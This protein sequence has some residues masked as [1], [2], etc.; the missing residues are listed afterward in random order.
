MQYHHVGES[1]TLVR[2]L[3]EKTK[4]SGVLATPRISRNN[5]LYYPEEL[6]KQNG[7]IVPVDLE[8]NH[9]HTIGFAKLMWNQELQRLEYVG[10]ISDH[11]VENTLQDGVEYHTSLEGGCASEPVCSAS[12]CHTACVA[13]TSIDRMALVL[14]PGIPE[15]TVNVV[16]SADSSHSL[17]S[18]NKQLLAQ[19]V[20]AKKT[21]EELTKECGCKKEA[22]GE[23]C[24]EGQVYDSEAQKCVPKSEDK[25]KDDDKKE[26]LESKLKELDTVLSWFRSKKESP[27]ESVIDQDSTLG[28]KAR[29]TVE[30]AGYKGEESRNR[31]P[32]VVGT[33]DEL[34]TV[35]N[36]LIES[37]KGL[38]KEL[39]ERGREKV[40]T[41]PVAEVAHPSGM[42]TSLR[43]TYGRFT[44]FW[45]NRQMPSLIWEVKKED[46]LKE[47]NY[48]P[49]TGK[50]I[51]NKTIQETI[52]ATNVPA[53][54]FQNRI[55]LDP[56]D[57]TEFAARSACNVQEAGPGTD[58]I[59]WY[60]G[61]AGGA[62]F[63]DQTVGTSF[64]DRTITVTRQQA[65]L[66]KRVMGVKV[67]YYDVHDIPGGVLEHVN[68]A[69]GLRAIADE[70]SFI[71]GTSSGGFAESTFTPT[72][73]VRGDTG[74]E[75]TA[76]N[77][78]SVVMDRDGIVQAK[79][80]I[81]AQGFNVMPG[82][83]VTI[84]APKP[85]YELLVDT[86]LDN[87]YQFANPEIT[88][89]AVLEGIYGTDIAVSTAI[90]IDDDTNDN[91]LNVM[92]TK[93]ITSGLGVQS[94]GGLEFEADRRNDVAQVFVS[95]RHRAIG[96]RILEESGCRITT[97]V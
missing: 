70:N 3:K 75:I 44:E 84:L 12:A 34:R 16:E 87:F 18:K 21:K 27:R 2:K 97:T 90:P 14:E 33:S 36:P 50:F 54:T 53:V 48:N 15:T 5:V 77:L 68:E 23:D 61:N 46:W 81:A 28:K 62:G 8:H 35:I 64:T 94:G 22:N 74:A 58:L 91:F 82:A 51:G 76:N 79:R 25:D 39:G 1:K 40:K 59:N 60:T 37:L 56:T 43:E 45:N 69:I 92:L 6:A 73:W 66:S 88:R 13:E 63:E 72:N 10:E 80:L 47:H 19:E 38:N 85:Y 42:K 29:E 11:Q 41:Q 30:Q 96:K 24:P 7:K 17:P 78:A 9:E 65:Q 31:S 55:I 26:A 83:Q 67:G 95:G 89:D 71:V 86:N 20:D 32:S 57:L 4:I 49:K 93:G 52:T